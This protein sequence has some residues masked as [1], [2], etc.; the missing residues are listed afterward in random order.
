MCFPNENIYLVLADTTACFCFPKI[1]TDVTGSF[2]FL[3][4]GLYFLSTGHVFGSNTSASSW[5]ALR[6][7]IQNMIPIYSQWTNLV[8][9][10]KDLIDLLKWDENL[11]NELVQAFK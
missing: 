10:Q 2:G 1:S 11:S 3:A 5:E 7:A 4:E 6:R 9:K 8:E